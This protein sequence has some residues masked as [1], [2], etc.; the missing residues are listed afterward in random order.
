VPISLETKKKA[1]LSDV[2]L[3]P[4]VNDV[5]IKKVIKH[6]SPSE[7]ER[8]Y[9]KLILECSTEYQRVVVSVET[10]KVFRI[11]CSCVIC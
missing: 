5:S 3:N 2:F 7:T 10:E 11:S 4:L 1:I 6:C 8:K 9:N